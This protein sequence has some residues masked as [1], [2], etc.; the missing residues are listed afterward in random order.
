MLPSSRHFA[1]AEPSAVSLVVA[2]SFGVEALGIF[3][4]WTPAHA[5]DAQMQ[6]R[7]S[8]C[9]RMYSAWRLRLAL[10]SLVRGVRCSCRSCAGVASSTGTCALGDVVVDLVAF[11]R[12]HAMP[13]AA[14]C[15]RSFHQTRW[16]VV[17]HRQ[18]LLSTGESRRLERRMGDIAAVD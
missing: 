15:A 9:L 14:S 2:A 12:V 7:R 3:T 18:Q 1:A 5:E 11:T 16:W 8:A 17:L 6:A 4:V 13:W 10:S